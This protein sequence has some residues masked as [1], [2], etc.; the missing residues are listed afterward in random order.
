MTLIERLQK[1][2]CATPDLSETA[3]HFHDKEAPVGKPRGDGH[4]PALAELLLLRAASPPLLEPRVDIHESALP[5]LHLVRAASPPLLGPRGDGHVP[6][7]P[8]LL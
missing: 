1:F 7:L 8:L 5:E 2:D 4:V 6:A 3:V